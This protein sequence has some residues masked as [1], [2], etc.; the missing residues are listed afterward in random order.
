MAEP[1]IQNYRMEIDYRSGWTSAGSSVKLY[2]PKKTNVL[3]SALGTIIKVV[4]ISIGTLDGWTKDGSTLKRPSL[5]QLLEWYRYTESGDS[6]DKVYAF[7]GLSSEQETRPL[8][9]NYQLSVREVFS[10][11]TRHLLDSLQSLK[12][13]SLKKYPVDG[14]PTLELPS[15][16]PDFTV[17]NP[18]RLIN[19]HRTFAASKGL[20]W[21]DPLYLPDSKLQLRGFKLEKIA[22]V[23]VAFKWAAISELSLLVQKVNSPEGQ[24]RFE[25][26]WRTI[27][28]DI[29]EEKTPASMACGSSF[30]ELFE[31]TVLYRQLFAAFSL[32]YAEHITEL[33][34]KAQ[35]SSGASVEL[36][37][38]VDFEQARMQLG[39]TYTAFQRM[40]GR[41]IET[42][43]IVFPPEFVDFEYRRAASRDKTEDDLVIKKFYNELAERVDQA[44][45]RTKDDVDFQIS[46]TATGRSLFVTETGYL[47]MGPI[48]VEVG[49]EMWIFPG[50]DIPLILRPSASSGEEFRLVGEAY[51]HGIMQGEAVA[52]VQEQDLKK[53]VLV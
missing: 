4:R 13:F 24:T 15:W 44:K 19:E 28:L 21:I 26:F 20:G 47:G 18:V 46:A 49:D 33:R 7:V 41:W 38:V 6:R 11:V 35:T 27:L 31:M 51:V 30:L 42:D 23:G 32:Q 37:E 2:R 34:D 48:V 45:D 17:Q 1:L 40:M 12:I 8:A 53:V 52:D 36:R 50:A 16:V 10:D 9:V 29:F 22:S 39:A 14:E 3:D 43:G 25:T 5:L